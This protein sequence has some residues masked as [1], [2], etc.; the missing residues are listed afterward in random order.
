MFAKS[1]FWFVFLAV[2]IV[3]L[4]VASINVSSVSAG[5]NGQQLKVYVSPSHYKQTVQIEGFNQYGQWIKYP[6]QTCNKLAGVGGQGCDWTLTNG[7]WWIGKVRVTV[8]SAAG[9]FSCERSV[10]KVQWTSNWYQISCWG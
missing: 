9:T 10:P 8:R 1:R 7:Y 5:T 2:M 3:G 6:L 4:M